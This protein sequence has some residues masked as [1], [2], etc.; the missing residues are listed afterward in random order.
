MG[1]PRE[2]I[3]KTKQFNL[4]EALN[5]A[6]VVTRDGREV[7]QLTKFETDEINC[8]YAVIDKS[9]KKFDIDGFEHYITKR[10]EPTLLI[11][12]EPQ[13]KWVNLYKDVKGRFYLGQWCHSLEEAKRFIDP[14]MYFVKTIEITDE[15]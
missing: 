8:I 11:E 1:I 7:T 15:R 4:E 6:K 13:R 5:G 14:S 12:V 2:T 9:V 10:G 3:M